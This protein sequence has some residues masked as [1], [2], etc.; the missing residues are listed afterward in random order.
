MLGN[1]NEEELPIRL[2]SS[3]VPLC[4]ADLLSGHALDLIWGLIL[5]ECKKKT[6]T[7]KKEAPKPY[8]ARRAQPKF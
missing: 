1:A 5:E 2:N 4:R 7:H 3:E 8:N 6:H